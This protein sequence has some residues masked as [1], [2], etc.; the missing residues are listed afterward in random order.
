LGKLGT[1]TGKRASLVSLAGKQREDSEPRWMTARD[2]M[3][4]SQRID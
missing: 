4:A 1:Q 2:I 3:E